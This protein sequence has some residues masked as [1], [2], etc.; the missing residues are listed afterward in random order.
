MILPGN[1]D[2][3]WQ[4]YLQ[5]FQEAVAPEPVD[6]LQADPDFFAALQKVWSCSEFVANTCIANPAMFCQL[7]ASGDLAASYTDDKW[8]RRLAAQL[9]EAEDEATLMQQLRH[10]RQRE[11]VRII[12]RDFTR[13]ADF[14]E[15][16]QDMTQLAETVLQQALDWLYPRA[17]D[18]W[19]TPV[20]SRGEAQRLV[21]LGMGKL[22]AGELNVSSDI[23]LI[24]AYS[25]KGETTGGKRQLSNQEFFVRLAQKLIRVIDE[26][27]ADGFVFR[28]DMRLR[29]YGQSGALVLC[30]DALETYYQSQGRDWE[31]YAMVKCRVVAGDRGAGAQL[32]E[33]LRPFTYRKYIDFGAIQALRDMKNLISR[34][35][36]RNAD[37]I[38]KG[39]GGIREV[40][41]IAQ[42]FQ[43]IRGGRDTRLQQPPLAAILPLLEEEQLLPSGIAE[44]LYQAYGFLRNIEHAL[45]GWRDQQ[46][47]QLPD[48]EQ[49]RARLAYLLGFS[50]WP[51]LAAVLQ[52][53]RTL[54]RQVFDGIVAD[55]EEQATLEERQ[56]VSR[57]T[58]VWQ[59]TANQA[60]ADLAAM[61]YGDPAEVLER[62]V[63][64]QQSRP[65]LT[66]SASGRTRLDTFM[67]LL[68]EACGEAEQPARALLRIMP[69]VEAVVRRSAYL[70]M[71]T[72]NPVALER[73]VMLCDG[74]PWIAAELARHPVL[75][76][77]LLDSRTLFSLPE[78]TLLADELRQQLLRI[79]SDDLEA[80][81]EVLRYF[82]LS[83][84]LRVAA[85]EITG[86]L[87]LMKVSDYLTWL[88]EAILE[89]VLAIAWEQMVAR[90]GSPGGAEGEMSGLAIIGYGKLGGIELAHGSDLDLV[91]LHNAE[92]DLTTNGER[93]VDN[94]TFFTRLGQRIIHILTTRTASGSLYEVDM[95]LRPSGNSGLLVTSLSSFANYQRRDAWTWEHQA[96]VRARAVAGD[97]RVMEKFVEIRHGVLTQQREMSALQK[98]VREM[99]RKMRAHLSSEASGKK[100]VFDLKQ[101]I[102]GIV[103]IEFMVQFA[104]LAWAHDFPGLTRWSDNIRILECLDDSGLMSAQQVAT[105][106]DA[107]KTYRAAGHR[108]QLQQQPGVVDAQQFVEL[109]RSVE[110]LWLDYLGTY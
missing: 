60:E 74:S 83:H 66:M 7:A 80:Q 20:N 3:L 109:R 82:R 33:M 31:R 27:T 103:D 86:A 24:F 47:Q 11:M 38:K 46:T 39:P 78:K 88:A 58:A 84:G 102:G 90:Y 73:L 87:P 25:D 92:I 6:W 37:D 13:Q 35:E 41:F 70:V 40:E 18:D 1:L 99:R 98:D 34:D 68:L 5:R 10:F 17:C 96:L 91:F 53:Q 44:R 23:D 100:A 101:D 22:S 8:Q 4:G 42:A 97:S 89:Q 75:L 54:I 63:Q 55:P 59:N 77:E 108:L 85:C 52:R 67:P 28:V 43:I 69:L 45:Q 51:A 64:L 95:R 72:E 21:V 2:T 65:V 36:R 15:T 93:Q 81:M 76:D 9:Q 110:K 107:Y 50:D 61:G 30:F 62:L 14:Q 105:L 49:G 56:Q 94:L 19:G 16:T 32:L 104:V 12:W 57:A 29:P 71:L 106:I 48:D 79:P 26:R